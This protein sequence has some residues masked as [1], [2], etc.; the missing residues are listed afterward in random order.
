MN[1]RTRVRDTFSRVR[2]TVPVC[3]FRTI[4]KVLMLTVV[5]CYVPKCADFAVRMAV[6]AVDVEVWFLVN[7][8]MRNLY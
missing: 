7:W 6:Q 4:D 8:H 2:N 1:G 3:C 5:Y